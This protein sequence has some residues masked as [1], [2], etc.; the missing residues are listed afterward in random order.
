[1]RE[2]DDDGSTG[3]FSCSS[4]RSTRRVR[5]AFVRISARKREP[6]HTFDLMISTEV[7]LTM[8]PYLASVLFLARTRGTRSKRVRTVVAFHCCPY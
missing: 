8:L 2:A 3:E 5:N 1:M 6:A 7:L 4:Y